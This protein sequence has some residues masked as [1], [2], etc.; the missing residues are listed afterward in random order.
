MITG[1]TGESGQK[2]KRVIDHDNDGIRKQSLTLRLAKSFSSSNIPSANIK[3][4]A[5]R[6][7]NAT[8]S[9][10]LGYRDGQNVDQSMPDYAG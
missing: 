1:E 2:L 9:L 10:S 7:G 3:D 5:P 6:N 8:K 4:T